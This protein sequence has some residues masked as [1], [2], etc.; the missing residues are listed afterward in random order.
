MAAVRNYIVRQEREVKVRANNPTTAIYLASSLFNDEPILLE[1]VKE[2]AED[3][4][5][6]LVSTVREIE[7]SA[8]E[9][10]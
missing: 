7:I 6:S 5:I 1:S 4:T 8:R 9:E 10:F 2:A 3:A